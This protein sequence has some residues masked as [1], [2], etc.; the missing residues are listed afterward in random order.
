M[1]RKTLAVLGTAFGLTACLNTAEPFGADTDYGFLVLEAR[2]APEAGFV[3]NPLAIFYRTGPVLLPTSQTA[4]DTCFVRAIEDDGSAPV[5][6]PTVHAGE[7]LTMLLSGMQTT[8]T[9]QNVA[10]TWM[11]LPDPGTAG[12]VTFTP[13][14][15]V[16]ITIPGAADG[17]ASLTQKA[18]TAEPFTHSPVEVP[19]EGEPVQLRWTASTILGSKMLVSLRYSPASAPGTMRQII[20]DLTDDGVY[21]IGSIISDEWR[22][23]DPLPGDITFSRWRITTDLGRNSAFLT[24]STF[25]LP[26]PLVP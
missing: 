21:D 19:L 9:R 17:F 11:Y 20:C 4:L 18:K 12:S 10:G 8:L 15:S 16:T 1:T 14:D 5:Y 22:T 24:I 13:G 7:P 6:P 25:E 23:S 2:T 3:V 26:T